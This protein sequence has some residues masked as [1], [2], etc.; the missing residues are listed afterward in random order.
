[1]VCMLCTKHQQLSYCSLCSAASFIRTAYQTCYACCAGSSA[2]S[3]NSFQSVA[4]AVWLPLSGMPTRHA[5]HASQAAPTVPKVRPLQGSFPH[6][7]SL[8][9]KSFRQVYHLQ[10]LPPQRRCT[11]VLL[12]QAPAWECSTPCTRS[13]Y[14]LLRFLPP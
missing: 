11:H 3:A 5:V 13:L 7:D 14:Q 2:G 10:L 12:H 9:D 6:L 8:P 4:S 1:M